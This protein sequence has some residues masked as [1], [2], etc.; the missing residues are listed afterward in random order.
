MVAGVVR[1]AWRHRRRVHRLGTRINL[2]RARSQTGRCVR[3]SPAADWGDD[4]GQV[5]LR[6][7]RLSVGISADI[8][9]SNMTAT[10]RSSPTLRLSRGSSSAG[11]DPVARRVFVGPVCAPTYGHLSARQ[12]LFSF[13]WNVGPLVWAD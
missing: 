10:S 3:P 6:V 4:Q 7:Y 1:H 12:A 2:D 9:S 13:A 11:Y 8:G 5:T